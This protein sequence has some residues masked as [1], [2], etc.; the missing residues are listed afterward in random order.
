M[1]STPAIKSTAA[2]MPGHPRINDPMLSEQ[3]HTTSQTPTALPHHRKMFAVAIEDLTQLA[4]YTDDWEVLA[5]SV[6][7]PL[8]A[9]SI[10]APPPAEST[11]APLTAQSPVEPPAELRPSPG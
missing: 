7:E 2:P 8:S 5:E 9:E 11:L 6:V 1:N 3:H 4:Q 10:V